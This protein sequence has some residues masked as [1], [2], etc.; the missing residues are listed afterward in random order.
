MAQAGKT[1]RIFV[2]STFSDLKA[3]RDA[4]QRQ[5]FPRLREL[6]LQ[7]G[8]RFQAIDLRWGVSEEASLDQQTMKIC[9]E[10]LRRCQRVT[11]RP[12]FI[13]LLGDR[14]GWRPLPYEIPAAEFGGILERLPVAAAER[15]R[16]ET[17]LRTWYRRDDNA[18]APVYVLKPREGEFRQGKAWE[19]VERELRDILA[20]ASRDMDLS[21]EARRKYL[22]SA[23]E[24]EIVQGLSLPDAPEHVFCFFRTIEN[25]P[26]EQSGA[27]F[28][29]LDARGRLVEADQR[30]L[31]RL[32]DDLAGQLP[33]NLH[34]Y[35]AS[36]QDRGGITTDHLGS[37]PESLDDCLK[38]TEAE[39]APAT[40]CVDVWRRLSRLILAEIAGL[41]KTDPLEQESAAHAAFG[42]E[43]VGQFV[44]RA[45]ILGVIRDYLHGDAPHPLSVWGESGAGKSALL[46]Q[47]GLAARAA[48]PQAVVVPRF[49][50]ATPASSD[51]RL[52][53]ESL[54][55]EISRVY[56]VREDDLP[57]EFRQLE[58]E[59]PRRL[60]L[61]TPDKPLIVILDALD[62]L[63]DA[64]QA[65]RLYWLPETLPPHV[66]LLVSTLPGEIRNILEKKLPGK[67]L[68]E[69]APMTP[70]EGSEL[71]DHWLREA[72]RTLQPHQRQE[73][74]G[75]F[76]ANG[77]PLYLRLAFEEARQ[78]HSYDDPDKT[79]LSP[80]IPGVIRDLFRRLSQPAH[81]GEVLVSRSLGYLAAGKNGL[82]EDELLEVLSTESDQAVMDDFK[83]RS[84]KSPPVEQLP[85]AVWSRLHIDMA[86][87]L[88]ERQADGAALL[89]FYHRQLAEVAK[90]EF[91]TDKERYWCHQMLSRYFVCQPLWFEKNRKK[92]PNLRKVS[93]LPYQQ[94]HG[95]MWKEVERTLCDLQFIEAK[96]SGEMTYDLVLDYSRL[97]LGQAQQGP[98]I[99]TPRMHN[100]RYG[101]W[102]PFCL[103]W[104]EIDK[105]KLGDSINCSECS[106]ELKI[107]H[108]FIEAE[109]HSSGPKKQLT[110]LEDPLNVR[111]SKRISAFADF[112]IS[113]RAILAHH[114]KLTYQQAANY[115]LNSAPA[116][117]ANRILRA[118]HDKLVWFEWV[119]KDKN[120]ATQ[121]MTMFAHAGNVNACSYSPDNLFILSCSDD[122][123]IK[124][125]DVKN[126]EL[127]KSISG[128]QKNNKSCIFSPDGGKILLIRGGLLEIWDIITGLK[129]LTL[130]GHNSLVTCCAYSPDGLFIV[131]GSEDKRLKIWDAV[132]GIELLTL[133]GHA[134]GIKF[135]AYSP[136]GKKI[137]SGSYK[138]LFVWDA[139]TG[140]RLFDEWRDYDFS[141]GQLIVT[142]M[143]VG[144]FQIYDIDS[145][146]A[147]VRLNN[148]ESQF[149]KCW[150]FSPDY[151][152]I[153][154]GFSQGELKV[155][156]IKACNEAI[157]LQG[158]S[159]DVT[160]CAFSPDGACII[161]GS[162]DQTVRIWSIKNLNEKENR[163]RHL[164]TISYCTYSPDNKQICTASSAEIHVLDAHKGKPIKTLAYYVGWVIGV[165]YSP[166]GNLIVSGSSDGLKVWDAKN[167]K[168]KSILTK[169]KNFRTLG[170]A[171]SPDG[172]RLVEGNRIWDTEKEEIVAELSSFSTIIHH[173]PGCKFSPDGKHV[174]SGN[175]CKAKIW[176]AETGNEVIMIEGNHFWIQDWAYSPDGHNILYGTRDGELIMWNLR[177]G[178][179]TDKVATLDAQITSCAY[180]P[181]GRH[182]LSA[183]DDGVIRLWN[184]ETKSIIT[185]INS[186]NTAY[187]IAFGS[188]GRKV[189]SGD[190]N[191]NVYLF[192]IMGLPD[193]PLF[194]TVVR[195]YFFERKR[196]DSDIS[197]RCGWCGQCFK[198][199]RT[200]FEA[201]AGIIKSAQ[202]SRDQS[203]CLELPDGAWEEPRLLSECPK[204]HKP[205][206]F[207]PFIVDN[208][209]RY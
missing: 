84:P 59:F 65:R 169:Y 37:L 44:G 152:K 76:A 172:R 68:L 198:P 75:K 124:L 81:H 98:P 158:H 49:I 23:T 166:D 174:F 110:K 165:C 35:E 108:F 64:E 36:W 11:P 94:T 184:L 186:K 178:E 133:I 159:D 43:R 196:W 83:K 138:Q 139:I 106:G 141:D 175:V 25:L 57:V 77:L 78:W 144:G 90:E 208:R 137:I 132:K 154:A 32:R 128:S 101:I 10:E 136:N 69:L 117:A 80:D 134:E 82:T 170:L 15:S 185:I 125:W 191:G 160:T 62:Q 60:A 52:L 73:V 55:R 79:R 123:N 34:I 113:Q 206:K 30:C 192:R 202:L 167:W 86:P 199:E 66:R 121:I 181:D 103:A 17:L 145:K 42:R 176:N 4:L 148:D 201:I 182:I 53:L 18:A 29:D 92:L 131:S 129:V 151:S 5:V 205:L 180:S 100:G 104:S 45:E 187:R 31:D 194:S 150:A 130:R 38:L 162:R 107:T 188:D 93:E 112:I 120:V 27:D 193:A 88:T 116:I 171:F 63:S 155:W 109:W 22:T 7:H 122:H 140:D 99:R 168:Q 115:P 46:A 114:P 142:N 209:D 207:N 156:D 87:Y 67:Q 71:L 126:G 127:I 21:S 190:Q 91:L 143:G 9:L 50:G 177:S 135:C 20:A 97:G 47:A 2:S 164:N 203:P 183:S 95:K 197:A 13:V 195:F 118:N 39:G 33:G 48:H 189:T 54:C 161:S 200:V 119:N 58:E 40:L 85:V 96:C 173:D 147:V 56:G 6:C 111:F 157:S 1:F 149:A 72:G 12:N 89:A 146:R 61:A 41:E 14:Y 19:P 26:E 70:K 105:D 8:C 3:E 179:K 204:C 74:L 28:I 24:Q 51:I 153:A 163:F 102:C 16:H